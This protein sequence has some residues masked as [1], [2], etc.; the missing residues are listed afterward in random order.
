VALYALFTLTVAC[1]LL[2]CAVPRPLAPTDLPVLRLSNS[3]VQWIERQDE[4]DAK[5]AP[6]SPQALELER[7]FL[8]YGVAEDDGGD[9]SETRSQR[10]HALAATYA[11]LVR[12]VGPALA[13]TMR[14]RALGKLEAALDLRLPDEQLKGVMGIFANV[15]DRHGATRAGIEIAPHF[16]VRTLYKARWNL[17]LNLAQ[18]FGFANIEKLAYHGWLALHAENLSVERRLSA[19]DA[20]ATAAGRSHAAQV[21]EAQGVLLYRAKSYAAAVDALQAAYELSGNVHLRNYVL[22]ARLAAGFDEPREN[23]EERGP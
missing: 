19:L 10:R 20:Y 13:L 5:R 14:A 1:A 4:R 9:S 22:G 3:A 7:R 17:A 18:D 6:S 8:D 21:A 15:L 16:V 12:E 23:A 11:D 2:L